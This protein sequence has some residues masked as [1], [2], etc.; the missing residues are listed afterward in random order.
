MR[1]PMDYGSTD[2]YYEME[3]TILCKTVKVRDFGITTK[4]MLT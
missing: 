1:R 2:M 3:G 4:Q